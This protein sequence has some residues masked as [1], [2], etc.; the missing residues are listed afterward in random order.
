MVPVGKQTHGTAQCSAQAWGLGMLN[1][2]A[3]LQ[4]RANSLP[5][6]VLAHQDS[7]SLGM[8]GSGE[9]TRRGSTRLQKDT[10]S[11]LA[12]DCVLSLFMYKRL[13]I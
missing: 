1:A 5:G 2:A 12:F 4:Y 10:S 9:W 13:S 3:E 8:L 11:S 6:T 7:D